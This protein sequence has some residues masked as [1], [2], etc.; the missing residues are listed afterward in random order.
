MLNEIKI[1]KNLLNSN[2]EPSNLRNWLHKERMINAPEKDNLKLILLA[3]ETSDV[4]DVSKKIMT[5]K[6]RVEKF[7]R[8]NRDDIKKQIE[9]YINKYDIEE[10]DEFTLVVNSVSIVVKHGVVKHKM[11]TVNLKMEQDKIGIII[12]ME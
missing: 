1:E 4:N 8:K 11:E 12:N 6:R 10:S 5:A 3:A 2:P 9:K 7:D